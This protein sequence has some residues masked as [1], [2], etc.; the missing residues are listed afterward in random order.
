MNNKNNDIENFELI[1][2]YLAGEANPEEIAAIENW[3]N[4][5]NQE[6]FKKIK[7]VWIASDSTSIHFD[8]EKALNKVNNRI[9]SSDTKKKRKLL[10]IYIAVAAITLFILIPTLILTHKNLNTE[11][12]MLSYTSTDSVRQLVLADGSQLTL[13]KNTKIEYSKDFEKNRLVKLEGEAF[14]EVQHKDDGNNFVVIAKDCQIT[15]IGT[16]FNI[17]AFADSDIVEISVKEGIVRVA[18]IDSDNYI[19]L[20]KD[21]KAVFDINSK[22]ITKTITNNSADIYWKTKEIVFENASIPE[23]SSVISDVYNIDVISELSNA[24]DLKLNTSFN[25]N[26]LDEV[27]KILQLT[28][29]IKIEKIDNTIILKDAE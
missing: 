2:K 27:I 9:S 29:D 20:T 8:T 19:S 12:E 18:E 6:E 26:S 17:K 22:E 13:N 1:A 5:G 16:K 4:S 15:V 21:E 3:I 7:A 23:V 25:N 14:F 11:S 28:L 24:E 10:P